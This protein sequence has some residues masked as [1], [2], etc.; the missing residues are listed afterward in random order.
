MATL[1]GELIESISKAVA[2]LS[3]GTVPH[4]LAIDDVKLLL[5]KRA[6]ASMFW[7]HIEHMPSPVR[8][9]VHEAL[10]ELLGPLSVDKDLHADDAL[11]SISILL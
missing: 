2:E 11:D 6:G 3:C 7:P 9:F 1:D 5:L 8:Q 10:A 4:H